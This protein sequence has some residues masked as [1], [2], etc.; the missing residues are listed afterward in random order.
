MIRSV[1][2]K[3]LTE[4]GPFLFGRF[5]GYLTDLSMVLRSLDPDRQKKVMARQADCDQQFVPTAVDRLRRLGDDMDAGIQPTSG[6]SPYDFALVLY[7]E[8]SNGQ[9]ARQIFGNLQKNKEEARGFLAQLKEYLSKPH[10][11]KERESWQ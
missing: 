10:A 2:D 11:Q 8:N 4:N 7:L 5:G 6:P 9:Y 1:V 3:H